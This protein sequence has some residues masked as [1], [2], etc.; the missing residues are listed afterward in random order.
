[1]KYKLRPCSWKY[2]WQSWVISKEQDHPELEGLWDQRER[3]IS[4]PGLRLY[5][6]LSYWENEQGMDTPSK[7]HILLLCC[8]CFWI[9]SGFWSQL[10]TP[11]SLM[12]TRSCK[13]FEASRCDWVGWKSAEVSPFVL[14]WG[15]QVN[16]TAVGDVGRIWERRGALSEVSNL[17]HLQS[18]WNHQT[19]RAGEDSKDIDN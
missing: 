17:S 14:P 13:D 16:D 6:C 9:T 18:F 12:R 19:T 4:S 15:V 8:P 10:S 5:K 3:N 2:P 1:M 11:C 7:H